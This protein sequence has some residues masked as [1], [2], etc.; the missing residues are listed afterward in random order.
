MNNT[1]LNQFARRTATRPIYGLRRK[2]HR[3]FMRTAV[4]LQ[5]CNLF[6]SANSLGQRNYD[7]DENESTVDLA[8]EHAM[9][10]GTDK[11]S[12]YVTWE[13][14]SK[15][16]KVSDHDIIYAGEVVILTVS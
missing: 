8:A 1:I 3:G 9:S 7:K 4:S 10:A 16:D 13:A 2:Y 14:F 15:V 12:A 11:P 6:S 5:Q